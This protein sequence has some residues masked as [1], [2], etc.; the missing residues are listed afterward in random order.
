MCNCARPIALCGD[1]KQAFL[2]IRIRESERDA[3]RFLWDGQTFRFTR[4]LFGLMSSP[5]LLNGVLKEHLAIWEPREPDVVQELQ[6]STYVDDL[7]SGSNNL[8]G[9]QKQK[10]TAKTIFSDAGFTLH[11]WNSNVAELEDQ[12][13]NTGEQTF[14]KSQL[15]IPQHE[16]R[17]LGLKWD[18]IKDTLAVSFPATEPTLT[19]RGILSH[20]AQIYDPLGLS[21][22]RT[23]GG[24]LIYR[25]AC[26]TKAEWDTELPPKL[27]LHWR[28]W[29]DSLPLFDVAPRAYVQFPE[30][31]DCM[32]F[33]AFGDA[34][35][36]G[37]AVAVYTVV[38]QPCDVTSNIVAARSRLA[39]EISIPHLKLVAAH[40]ATNL[41]TNVN[42]T[43]TGVALPD[44]YLWS[45]STVVL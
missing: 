6:K 22:P 14:A 43:L 24:K 36:D 7:I 10:T 2:Q 5:F 45:D 35:K 25:E 40:M 1:V 28:K 34:S 23:L 13:P 12:Q 37:V 32:E 4:A 39:K 18:K 44:Q 21:A 20:L 17:Q 27:K 9:A 38:R 16:T 31:I 19:K 42:A 3:L 29:A 33:H 8:E 15:N 11:K 30:P 26:K 41:L